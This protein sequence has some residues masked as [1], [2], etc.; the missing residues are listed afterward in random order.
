MNL[1]LALPEHPCSH[2]G[3]MERKGPITRPKGGVIL[4]YGHL[5]LLK[6]M[7]S[8]HQCKQKSAAILNISLLQIVPHLLSGLM[9]LKTRYQK[10]LHTGN[11]GTHHTAIIISPSCH[12]SR[13]R[14]IIRLISWRS[15]CQVGCK[16][17][18][19]LILF[20]QKMPILDS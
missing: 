15:V 16:T 10:R 8:L 13:T 2:L 1:F 18:A 14:T 11:S 9:V 19:P 7:K 5:I 4:L 12:C 17:M 3:T 20:R 6:I